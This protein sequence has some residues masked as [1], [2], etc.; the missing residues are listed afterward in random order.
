MKWSAQ[1]NCQDWLCPWKVMVI[2][3]LHLQK[4]VRGAACLCFLHSF[5]QFSHTWGSRDKRNTHFLISQQVIPAGELASHASLSCRKRFKSCKFEGVERCVSLHGN[6]LGKCAMTVIVNQYFTTFF[7]YLDQ[8]L[9]DLNLYSWFFFIPI[10]LEGNEFLSIIFRQENR[11]QMDY[12][13]NHVWA[14]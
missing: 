2:N 4:A 3:S 9:G 5:L 11:Q 8:Y 13:Y 1:S 6:I 14:G 10:F 12:S 7:C